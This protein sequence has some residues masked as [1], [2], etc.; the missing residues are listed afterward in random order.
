MEIPFDL[1]GIELPTNGTIKIQA[2]ITS[3]MEPASKWTSNQSLPGIQNTAGIQ[4]NLDNGGNAGDYTSA[5]GNQ[6]YTYE[7]DEIPEPIGFWIIG[8]LVFLIKGSV[9]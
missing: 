4:G 9:R 7:Y 2:I 6:Y 3:S 1:I 8:L 5:P